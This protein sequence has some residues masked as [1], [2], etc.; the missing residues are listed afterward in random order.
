MLSFI[1]P[2]KT[3]E[4]E[5]DYLDVNLFIHVFSFCYDAAHSIFITSYFCKIV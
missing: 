5:V 4:L 1:F 3:D 2:V